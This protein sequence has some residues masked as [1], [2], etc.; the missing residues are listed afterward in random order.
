MMLGYKT[1]SPA[2]IEAAYVFGPNVLGTFVPPGVADYINGYQ[3]TYTVLGQKQLL[4][5]TLQA[6]Y[7]INRGY[8]PGAEATL[9]PGGQNQGQTLRFVS[10]A[11]NI[12][13]YTGFILG[14]Q[15]V[16]GSATG[17]S[18]PDTY[19][20]ATFVQNLKRNAGQFSV[21]Y[22]SPP[23]AP[24]FLFP[25]AVANWNFPSS[26]IGCLA[27]GGLCNLNRLTVNYERNVSF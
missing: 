22:G 16:V 14:Y 25:R 3:Q 23:H 24:F 12:D 15:S 20:S 9:Y 8:Y 5:F 18:A 17:A 27:G 4:G 1:G 2:F 11:R 13:A 6:A 21:S 26:V 7:G 10:I 19:F